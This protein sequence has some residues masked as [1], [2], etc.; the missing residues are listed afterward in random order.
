MLA[1]WSGHSI[2]NSRQARCRF[3][4]EA[5]A[6]SAGMLRHVHKVCSFSVDETHVAAAEVRVVAAAAEVA[7]AGS[8]VARAAACPGER[9]TCAKSHDLTAAPPRG[10]T[11]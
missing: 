8:W 4:V 3:P 5:V 9:A 6:F 7:A 10:F 11:S 1:T 2:R